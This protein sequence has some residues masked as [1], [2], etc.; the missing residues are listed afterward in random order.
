MSE[1]LSWKEHRVLHG[2]GRGGHRVH[3]AEYQFVPRYQGVKVLPFGLA[4]MDNG[5]ILLMGAART[6]KG[7][8]VYG[9]MVAT[10]SADGGITW[11][12]YDAVGYGPA[13]GLTY[14]GGGSLFR[15]GHH[16]EEGP[17][18]YF[19]HD[20]GRTWPEWVPS[21]PAPNG[22]PWGNEGNA[23]VDFDDQGR[24]AQI[25]WNSGHRPDNVDHLP[26][27]HWPS[28]AFLCWSRDG[29]RTCEDYSYPEEWK[30]TDTHEGKTWERSCSEG[31]MVRAANGWLVVAKRMD[32]PARF[33]HTQYDSFMGTGASVSRDEGATWTPIQHVFEAGRHHANLLR[34]PN[35]DLVMVVV[36]RLDIREGRLASYRLGCDAVVS[37]DHGLTWNTDEMYILDDWPHIHHPDIGAVTWETGD[38]WYGCANGHQ[39]SVT[40]G[41]DSIL[42]SYGHYTYGG[43]LI[44]WRPA[45]G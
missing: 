22:R 11:S 3:P 12:D 25:G 17:C 29:G 31:A 1:A 23:L 43:A 27:G 24:A 37:H 20:Y 28:R 40:L 6:G 19:S 45:S 35:G 41:D 5:E 16:P 33:L 15:P 32:M 2:D 42:T 26:W 21:P 7:P 14:L 10:R 9:E 38:F 44:K 18:R 36:R 13:V 39:C 8:S 4:A 30:W 34:R